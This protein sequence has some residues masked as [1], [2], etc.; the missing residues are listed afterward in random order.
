L[1]G[2][3]L[4]VIY[5]ANNHA[6]VWMI[7]FAKTLPVPDRVLT[8]RAAWQPGNHEEGYLTGLDSLVTVRNLSSSSVFH[9]YM[10]P[11]SS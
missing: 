2:S 11:S 10:I 9:P 5:D 6:S 7:D 4:L 3:S 8:H 1:I